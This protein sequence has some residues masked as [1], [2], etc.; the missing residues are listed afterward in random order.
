MS[1][2]ELLAIDLD[3]QKV[4]NEELLAECLFSKETPELATKLP[5]SPQTFEGLQAV[6]QRSR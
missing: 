4:T 3:Q 6:S 5:N 1:G 2:D